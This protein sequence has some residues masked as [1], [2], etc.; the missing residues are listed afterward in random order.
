M[1]IFVQVGN[2]PV[3]LSVPA[4]ED[5]HGIPVIGF[6]GEIRNLQQFA[7]DSAVHLPGIRKIEEII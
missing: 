2:G 7:A 1:G 4:V 6:I 3:C 5:I